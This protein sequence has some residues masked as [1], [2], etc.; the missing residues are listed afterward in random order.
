MQNL[1]QSHNPKMLKYTKV[2]TVFFVGQ[3]LLCTLVKIRPPLI[4]CSS[5]VAYDTY[6]FT[7]SLNKFTFLN[8][9]REHIHLLHSLLQLILCRCCDWV[10]IIISPIIFLI[11]EGTEDLYWSKYQVYSFNTP[12][13]ISL[14]SS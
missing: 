3:L 7:F 4:K 14:A 13:S 8:F 1:N 9:H 2:N 6:E 12:P 10:H 11:G 5:L